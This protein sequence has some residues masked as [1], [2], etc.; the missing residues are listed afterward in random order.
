MISSLV[1]L[2]L[3]NTI[4]T[5]DQVT[6]SKP[7][8]EPYLSAAARLGFEPQLCIAVENS[9]LGVRSA[10]AAG[11]HC[12]AVASTV[13]QEVLSMADEIVERFLCVRGTLGFRE[14]N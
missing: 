1:F 13:S 6:F 9:P 8:P 10:K 4:V 11:T 3:F 12:V 5:G 2:K 7:H 14:L